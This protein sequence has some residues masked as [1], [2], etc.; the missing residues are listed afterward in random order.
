V[1]RTATLTFAMRRV[2]QMQSVAAN[3]SSVEALK[4]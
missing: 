4:R 2:C 1:P 3:R